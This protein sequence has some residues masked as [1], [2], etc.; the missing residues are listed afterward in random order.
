MFVYG[1]TCIIQVMTWHLTYTQERLGYL[2]PPAPI[3]SDWLMDQEA[4]RPHLSLHT[5]SVIGRWDGCFTTL[6]RYDY[7]CFDVIAER[8]GEQTC[9]AVI[10]ALMVYP[11]PEWIQAAGDATNPLHNIV[12]QKTAEMGLDPRGVYSAIQLYP[13]IDLQKMKRWYRGRG[14]G[15]ELSAYRACMLDFLNMWESEPTFVE[16]DLDKYKAVL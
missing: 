5:E 1:S 7:G 4:L 14:W 16:L 6:G 9:W 13:K 8:Y 12:S 3:L 10:T 11:R 15:C 2:Y